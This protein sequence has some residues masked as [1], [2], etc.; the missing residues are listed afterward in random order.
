MGEK[1]IGVEV[2]RE[3]GAGTEVA[4]VGSA[5]FGGHDGV[6]CL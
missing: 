4:Y 1:E 3:S 5:A 2:L 6:S